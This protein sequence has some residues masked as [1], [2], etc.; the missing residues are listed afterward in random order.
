VAGEIVPPAGVVRYDADDPYLV[1]AADKGTATFSDTANAVA[2]EYSFW[3]GD[4]FASGGSAGYDHKAMGITARGAWESVRSH[5]RVLGK[6]ADLDELTVVGVGDMSGDVFGNG[7]LRSPHLKLVGAFDHRH[8]FVDPDPDPS[9]SFAERKRLYDTPRSS[10]ADYDPALISPGG[11]VFA[12]NAKS[13]QLTPE[14]R[15]ALGT[16]AERLT[17]TELIKAVLRAP[18]DLLWNGGI[19]TYVKS[20]SETHSQVGDRANDAVR[21][22][23]R[24]LRCRIVGE[25]GNLG[26][27]QLGRNEY[28]LAGGLIYTDAIDNSAGVDCSDHEVNIKILLGDV[29]AAGEMT[30]EQ[31]ND[32][33]DEMTDEVAEL[34]LDNNRAQTLALMIARQQS[35]PM[36]NVHARYLEA[37]EREGWLDRALEF[38]PTDKQIAERQSTGSGL[39][40]PEL[41]VLIAYT[42]NANVSEILASELPE[43]PALVE[44]LCDY[45]PVPLRQRF[46]SYILRHR[47]RREIATTKLVNQMANL[48]GISYDHRM[49]E[50][51][52]AS[53][54]DVARA[55]LAVREVLDFPAWWDEIGEL[56][57]IVLDDQLE[58][59]LDCRR[60][61]ERCSLWILRHRRPPVDIALEVQRFRE[62][63]QALT[64]GLVECLHGALREAVEA[65]T[66]RRVAQGVPHGLAARSAVWR[67]LHTTFDVIELAERVEVSLP[68]ACASYWG[69]FDRLELMWLWD[70]I[71]ALAR[72]DRWQT[73]ARGSLRDDLLSALAELTENVLDSPERTVDRW[74]AANQR[75]VQRA[76]AQLTEIR[77]ADAFDITNLS[78]ALRQLRNL[79]LASDRTV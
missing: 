20:S 57:D 79:A 36:I 3:L 10:W 22:D 8:V 62:P 71:G 50:D 77:R 29:V 58:L 70:G 52:G 15:A 75:S 45:F 24:E 78:V 64:I 63:V 1:V 25:G 31:R 35:L 39:T 68:E 59:Y 42:K 13:V 19:G 61:A 66:A 34:V 51:T 76:M 47:L 73:Q 40:T 56:T 43:D 72:S 54:A 4:A 60:A 17:P 44:D 65:M 55:W 28:A 23:G 38:L 49:T 12:R 74:W 11:G 46:G 69:L 5:A 32:L 67:L 16:S 53:V 27:T 6:N 18:V 26:F 33:L 9:T 37:L 41:A 7:L 48:S 2:A 30:L 14:M 21:I